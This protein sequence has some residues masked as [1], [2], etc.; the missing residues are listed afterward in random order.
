ML[1]LLNIVVAEDLVDDSE[2]DDICADIRD[3]MAET[4]TVMSMKV[5]RPSKDDSPVPGLGR[6]FVEFESIEQAIRTKQVVDGMVFDSRTVQCQY[7]DSDKYTA[8]QLD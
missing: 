8:N 7:L 4:G 3:K 6:V 2:Y 5:P 1:V